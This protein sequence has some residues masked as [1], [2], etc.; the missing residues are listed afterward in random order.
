M[1]FA[2][3]GLAMPFVNLYLVSLGF[4]GTQIGLLTSI[5]ALAQLSLAP[6]LHNLADRSGRQRRLYFGLL[7]ANICACFGLV[8]FG[9][10]PGLLGGM[11]VFRD[12]A[13]GPGAAMLSQLTI[14]WLAQRG[15]QIYGRLRAWGSL[16]WAV[17]TMLSG[18]IFAIGGYPLLFTLSAIANLAALPF[19]RVL[20]PRTSEPRIHTNS[21]ESQ[22]PRGFYILLASMFLFSVG[23]TAFNAFSYIYFKQDLGASNQL[24]GVISSLAALSEIPAMLLMDRLL[25]RIDIRITL[26]IGLMGLG[27]LWFSVSLLTSTTL[28][29]PLMLLRGTFYTLQIVSLTLLVSRISQPSSVATNQALAQVTVPGLA[30][31]LT[32]AVSGWLFDHTGARGLFQLATLMTVGSIVLLFVGKKQLTGQAINDPD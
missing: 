7:I 6:L 26:A 25:R 32:G 11:I 31:L 10:I 28:L 2:A 21:T 3:R 5:S 12:L 19:A 30:I 9:S 15:R 22:R 4:T 18:T 29:I 23:S 17:A 20:P 14:T 16:G 8:A 1:T 24:I 13:D 27:V